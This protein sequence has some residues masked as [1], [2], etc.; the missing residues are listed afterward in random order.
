M[1]KVT[2]ATFKKFIRENEGKLLI[3]VHSTFDGMVDCVT[4]TGNKEF[5]PA[6]KSDNKF[7]ADRTLGIAGIW[8]VGQSRDYFDLFDNG[9]IKGIEVYNS[10]GSYTVGIYK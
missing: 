7:Y 2:L 4:D 8:L 3:N 10:C 9:K 1:K 5:A 6:K